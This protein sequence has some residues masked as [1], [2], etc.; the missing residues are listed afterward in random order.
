ML[1]RLMALAVLRQPVDHI[2]CQST[3]FQALFLWID[4]RSHGLHLVFKL[5]ALRVIPWAQ[6][7]HCKVNLVSRWFQSDLGRVHP[8]PCAHRISHNGFGGARLRV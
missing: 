4:D 5:V 3:R 6:P 1:A 2:F 7:I 8:L